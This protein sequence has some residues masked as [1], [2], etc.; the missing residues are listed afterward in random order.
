MKQFLIKISI[1][2]VV[3]IVCDVIIG[4]T[5][6]YM[7]NNITV[8]GRGRD[9]YICDKSADDILIFGSSRAVHHYNSSMI[10]DS[11]GMSCYNCGEDGN[12]IIL[13][14][15]RLRMVKERHQ[16]KI[17]IHDINPKFDWLINDNSKYLGWL[18]T[19]YKRDGIAEIFE[20]ID[21]L[22]KY[23]LLSG[24]YR[25]NS[26][27]LQNAVTYISSVSNDT[28]VKG[29]RP[30]KGEMDK[31][32]ISFPN[33]N[34]V[35][36]EIGVDSLK[37]KYIWKLIKASK[38]SKLYFVT[39]PTWYGMDSKDLSLIR[40]ICNSQKIELIDFSNNPKYVHNDSF[41]KDGTHLNEK[42]ANEFTRDLINIIKQ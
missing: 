22:E 23:R 42:G 32:K 29:Y 12:G 11:L 6:D 18:K 31:M 38:G 21:R 34:K 16:P 33:N 39:S 14:Y 20:D 27:F 13:S 25:H 30:M 1:L 15:G 9:N 37:L 4:K 7:V 3:I 40:S 26:V 41:F 2:A 36:G 8:G 24:L 28:G 35:E 10:E 19:R 5:M 17:I